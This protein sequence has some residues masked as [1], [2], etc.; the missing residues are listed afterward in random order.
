MLPTLVLALAA[1]AAAASA[2]DPSPAA[3]PSTAFDSYDA[4]AFA[5]S[6]ADAW[7]DVRVQSGGAARGAFRGGAAAPDLMNT[8]TLFNLRPPCGLVGPL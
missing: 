2:S 8:Q 6:G 4:A 3:H 1:L 5:A 7:S